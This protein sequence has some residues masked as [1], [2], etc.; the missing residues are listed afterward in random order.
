MPPSAQAA[1]R[2]LKEGRAAEVVTAEG[3]SGF[4][5]GGCTLPVL[6]ATGGTAGVM[7]GSET[8]GL[9]TS[10]AA[11][12]S[13]GGAGGLIVSGTEDAGD[14]ACGSVVV[15][16]NASVRPN[17]SVSGASLGVVVVEGVV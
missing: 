12:V 9:G 14:V 6:S 8:G 7:G 3:F 2:V 4:T 16:D 1:R 11:T 17:K 15:G 13:L 10:A 5:V